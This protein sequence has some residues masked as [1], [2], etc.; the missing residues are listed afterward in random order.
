MVS[1]GFWK[2]GSSKQREADLR[3]GAGIFGA[4]DRAVNDARWRR[5]TSELAAQQ[6]LG[7][8]KT[9]KRRGREREK[10]LRIVQRKEER[11]RAS[12]SE[13]ENSIIK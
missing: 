10:M 13:R 5:K 7:E 2:S 11:Q 1:I 12:E 6:N 4:A 8:R 9:L 3:E